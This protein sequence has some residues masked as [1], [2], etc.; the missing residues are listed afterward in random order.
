MDWQM[1]QISSRPFFDRE[2]PIVA[3]RVKKNGHPPGRAPGGVLA[4]DRPYEPRSSSFDKK[5]NDD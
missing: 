5:A 2:G 1:M 3:M 4:A